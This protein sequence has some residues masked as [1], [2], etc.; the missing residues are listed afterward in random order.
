M[1]K[2]T[3]T[4]KVDEYTITLHRG[5]EE[6]KEMEQKRM[7]LFVTCLYKIAMRSMVKYFEEYYPELLPEVCNILKKGES[8][9]LNCK[10]EKLRDFK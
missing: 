4:Y 3:M 8:K 6:S 7:A 2:Q 5:P 10:I 1:N 9:L